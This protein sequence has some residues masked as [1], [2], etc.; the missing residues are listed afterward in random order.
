MNWDFSRRSELGLY[1][2]D[3]AI[4]FSFSDLNA[5]SH[6]LFIN[7]YTGTRISKKEKLSSFQFLAGN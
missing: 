5:T 2:E 7:V 6:I 1:D 4:Y 3:E